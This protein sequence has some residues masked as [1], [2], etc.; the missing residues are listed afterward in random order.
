[1]TRL[2]LGI[3]IGSSG[4]RAIAIEADGRVGM[5]PLGLA[6]AIEKRHGTPVS[7]E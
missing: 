2:A 6:E 3:D 7:D 4:V 5:L 1:M